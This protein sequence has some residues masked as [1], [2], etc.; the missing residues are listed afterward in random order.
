[1]TTH[2]APLRQHVVCGTGNVPNYLPL[3]LSLSLSL[4]QVIDMEGIV[5]L[6]VRRT[7]LML[8]RYFIRRDSGSHRPVSRHF[9]APALTSLNTGKS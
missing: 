7:L 1:M 2:A 8:N 6:N 5:I 9:S 3:S 4:P